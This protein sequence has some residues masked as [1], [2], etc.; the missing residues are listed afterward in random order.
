MF[1]ELIK[2][3]EKYSKAL[4][5]LS[6]KTGICYYWLVVD[7]VLSKLFFGCVI[8]QYTL[9]AFYKRKWF[10]RKRMLTYGRWSS[11]ITTYNNPAY[12]HVLKYKSDFNKYFSQFIGREWIH[13]SNMDIA[14][15]KQFVEK[16]HKLIIKPVDG[17]EG[18]GVYLVDMSGQDIES[19]FTDLKK[20]QVLIEECVI[21]HSQ[22]RYGNNSVNTIRVYTV[23]DKRCEQAFVVK[24]VVRVGVGDSIVDNSHSGGCAYEVDPI[25]GIIVSPSYEANGDIHIIHPYTDICMLGRK[26][27]H[28]DR[29]IQLCRVAASRLPQVAFIGW[30]VA[31]KEDGPILIEGNH[32]PD[33]D[34][35]EFVGSY[36]YY[37]VIMSHLK[38]N[39]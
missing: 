8:N 16:H 22:M 9:G 29:V 15:F 14:S 18:E 13:S 5:Q 32:D 30:D 36:G 21:Q 39:S 38:N 10:E 23:F 24:T 35:V 27:P 33:L 28:W 19:I 1:F 4:R 26:I 12:T 3:W 37:N 11:I 17:W 2:G 6:A 25:L 20:K 31:I 7:C 34:M